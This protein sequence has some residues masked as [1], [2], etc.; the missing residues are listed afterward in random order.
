VCLFFLRKIPDCQEWDEYASLLAYSIPSFGSVLFAGRG[1]TEKLVEPR[2]K[3]V[4]I[5]WM[6]M[7]ER[8]S[9]ERLLF[10]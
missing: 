8:E 5:G 7:R 1:E 3:K 2:R 6:G 4:D 10:K 9:G